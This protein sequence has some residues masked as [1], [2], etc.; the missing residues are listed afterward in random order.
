MRRSM[1]TDVCYESAR[2]KQA[3]LRRV[4]NTN[5][6][7]LLERLGRC[8]EDF[9]YMQILRHANK[10]VHSSNNKIAINNNL[11]LEATLAVMGIN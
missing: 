9:I 6:K 7:I 8:D 4:K 5:I 1:S 11:Y 2:R 3:R 10:Q